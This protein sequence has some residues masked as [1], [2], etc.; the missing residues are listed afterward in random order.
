[1]LIRST[2]FSASLLIAAGSAYGH[3]S[4][5]IASESDGYLGNGTGDVTTGG[6]DTCLRVGTFSEDNQINACEGI[7]DEVVEEVVEEPEE[8]A[9]ETPPE[10]EPVDQIVTVSLGGST[11]FETNSSD[12]TAEGETTIDDLIAKLATYQTIN[13]LTVVGHTDS[14]G[15][16]SYNQ[17]LSERRA[18]T[19]ASRLEA[20]YPNA[21]LSSSG[22]G[23]SSPVA[24]NDTAAGRL[25][26]RRVTITIDAS[27]VLPN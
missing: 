25:L 21:S 9:V 14:R 6:I 22:A 24:T 1:M 8:V 4:D 11:Q 13:S 19:V 12:L 18:A 3:S 2:L 17:A 10:P 26:N 15:S 16:E 5:H 23:E 20:A 7:E 27:R